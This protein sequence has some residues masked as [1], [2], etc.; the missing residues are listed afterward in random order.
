[1]SGWGA[2]RVCVCVCVCAQGS[3]EWGSCKHLVPRSPRR[4]LRLGVYGGRSGGEGGDRLG[5]VSWGLE[6]LKAALLERPGLAA[7]GK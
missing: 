4:K 1:V 3:R 7:Q 5:R 2:T 6:S